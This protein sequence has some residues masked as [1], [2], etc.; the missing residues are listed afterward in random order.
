MDIQY[1][2]E[3]KNFKWLQE[4]WKPERGDV[5]LIDEGKWVEDWI[6]TRKAEIRGGWYIKTPEGF[7]LC[8]ELNFLK[9][10]GVYLPRLSTLIELLGDRFR[11]L[12]RNHKF[13]WLCE[14]WVW[15]RKIAA[16]VAVWTPSFCTPKLACLRALKKV[17]GE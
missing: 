7:E 4:N 15:D 12:W 16:D 3:C 9:E 17:K 8:K 11:Q 6:V 1:I 10:K 5:V 2:E 13:E 14:Y